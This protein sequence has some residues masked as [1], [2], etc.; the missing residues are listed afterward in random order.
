MLAEPTIERTVFLSTVPPTDRDRRLARAVVLVSFV[1]F[2]IAAP[3]AKVRLIEVWPFI[4]SHQSVLVVTDLITAI[5]LF[6]Q[7]RTLGDRALATLATGYLFTALMAV[8]HA[9]TFRRL[10]APEGLLGGGSLIASP[11][12]IATCFLL[13]A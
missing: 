1:A 3:F 12:S 2:V 8:V 6:A 10:F 4:P 5:L 13:F 7:F 9:L 11:L